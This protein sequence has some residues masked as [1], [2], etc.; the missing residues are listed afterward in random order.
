MELLEGRLAGVLQKI[1]RVGLVAHEVVRE[2][3]GRLE[4][5]SHQRLEEVVILLLPQ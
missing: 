1:F 3:V 4:L 5:R 2:T